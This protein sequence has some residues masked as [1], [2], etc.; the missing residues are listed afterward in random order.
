MSIEMLLHVTVGLRPPREDLRTLLFQDERLYPGDSPGQR[1]TPIG[2]P[3]PIAWSHEYAGGRAWFTGLG[4]RRE[5]YADPV[6]LD[7]LAGGIVWAAAQ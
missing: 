6:F 4:Y 2:P 5:L 1:F 3:F 7:H